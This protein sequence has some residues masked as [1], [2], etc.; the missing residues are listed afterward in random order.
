MKKGFIISG[1][2]AVLLSATFIGCSETD[3]ISVVPAFDAIYCSPTSPAAGDSITLTAHQA[4]MGKLINKTSYN[5]TFSCHVFYDGA[6]SRDTTFTRTVNTNYDG[7]SNADP[8]IG[9]FVPEN[10]ASDLTVTLHANYS[11]S[12]QTAS[13]QLYGQATRTTRIPITI[14][15]NN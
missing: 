1:L 11:L 5:W 8:V 15:L 3:G 10:I 6:A 12:G 13:G 14:P 7:I 9:V 2:F 4:Q